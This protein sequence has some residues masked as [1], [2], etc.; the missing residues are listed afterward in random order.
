MYMI[1][2]ENPSTVLHDKHKR[3]GM[4]NVVEETTMMMIHQTKKET[5]YILQPNHPKAN[6]CSGTDCVQFSVDGFVSR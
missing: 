2:E 4:T 5:V 1:H 6:I 3:S